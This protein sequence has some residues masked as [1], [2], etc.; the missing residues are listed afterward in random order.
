MPATPLPAIDVGSARAAVHLQR[1]Y[2]RR[3]GYGLERGRRGHG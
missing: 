3:S 1:V 2:D